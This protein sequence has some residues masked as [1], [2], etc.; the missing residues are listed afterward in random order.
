M[1]IV[2]PSA[3]QM[4]LDMLAASGYEAYV[5]GGCVRDSLLGMEPKDW[6]LS[7]DAARKK[8]WLSS[9][10]FHIGNGIKHG[11]IVSSLWK[12]YEIT[13]YRSDGL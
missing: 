7:T 1:K 13:T 6:D 4:L 10:V 9:A 8:F 2:L 11:T 5:V 3:V 12:N